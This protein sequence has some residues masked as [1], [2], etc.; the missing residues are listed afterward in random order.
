MLIKIPLQIE[1]DLDI[2]LTEE[3]DDIVGKRKPTATSAT[4]SPKR[5]LRSTRESG[6]PKGLLT[7]LDLSFKSGYL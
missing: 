5:P 4:S 3:D 1:V 2:K 6:V 7:I